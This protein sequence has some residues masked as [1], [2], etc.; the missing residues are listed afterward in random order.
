MHAERRRARGRARAARASGA[1]TVA[2]IYLQII[3]RCEAAA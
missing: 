3:D 2:S 1:A